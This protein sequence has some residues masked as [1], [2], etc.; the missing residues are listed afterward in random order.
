MRLDIGAIATQ[1][2]GLVHFLVTVLRR[3]RQHK[4]ILLA[5]GI[6]YNTLLSI[7]PLFIV[8]LLILSGFFEERHLLVAINREL[9]FVVPGHADSITNA[10]SRFVEQKNV[11]GG[12][13]LA[14]LLFFSSIAFRNFESAME[15]VFEAHAPDRHFLVSVLL[16]Y[17][18]I[19]LLGL[20]LVALTVA[21]AVFDALAGRTLHILQ[22]T[23]TVPN[24][25][26]LAVYLL[27]FLGLILLFTGLYKVVPAARVSL[28]RAAFGAVVASV[29]WEIVRRVVFWWFTSISVV[30][31]VYGSLTTVIIA[32]LTMEVAAVIVL[33][34][35]QVT[36]QL[37]ENAE[38]DL[39]WYGELE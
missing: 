21:T 30:N 3:F 17:G 15:I 10:V 7:V 1:I 29:L 25:S 24:V 32:L 36:A 26:G 11:V 35:A 19:V 20:S 23:M 37:Q 14:M 33:L 28:G 38:R 12:V 39:P 34:G 4:G 22:F 16:P 18:F 13:V 2:H 9:S 27:S 5:G 31:V 8:L 6:A